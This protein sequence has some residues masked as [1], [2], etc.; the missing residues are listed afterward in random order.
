MTDIFQ[1]IIYLAWNYLANDF[2]EK[3]NKSHAL[4]GSNI[5]VLTLYF[6]ALAV[7][8]TV[9]VQVFSVTVMLLHAVLQ[10][11]VFI[12]VQV[13]LAVVF[14]YSWIGL[15]LLDGQT[16]WLAGN[17]E[18]SLYFFSFIKFLIRSF[19]QNPQMCHYCFFSCFHILLFLATYMFST[20]YLIS[21]LDIH[22]LD[23]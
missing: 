14:Q 10:L 12:I 22:K 2:I 21:L 19:L 23:N 15:C 11:L 3:F 5:L 20:S 8:F 16:G 17:I 9:L 4:S 18:I 13:F 7:Q 6:P 1:F